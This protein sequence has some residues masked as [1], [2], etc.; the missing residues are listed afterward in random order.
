MRAWL[1]TPTTTSP[2]SPAPTS[3]AIGAFSVSASRTGGRTC[4]SSAE[5]RTDKSCSPAS[6]FEFPLLLLLE[7]AEQYEKDGIY[8][9]NRLAAR[10]PACVPVP[11]LRPQRR[12]EAYPAGRPG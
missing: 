3:A 2:S 11:G 5:T 1:C 10:K 7:V 8:E 9:A 12:R 4:T 6:I